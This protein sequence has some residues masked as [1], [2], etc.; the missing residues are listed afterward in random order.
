MGMSQGPT[1]EEVVQRRAEAQRLETQQLGAQQLEWAGSRADALTSLKQRLEAQRLK[2]GAAA[3]G[4]RRH[5]T[6]QRRRKK[7]EQAGKRKPSSQQK[8]RRTCRPNRR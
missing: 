7:L 8:R 4:W 5:R 2:H 3:T 6:L 1:Q